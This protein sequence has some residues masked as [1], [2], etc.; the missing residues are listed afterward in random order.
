MDKNDFQREQCV[1]Y[2]TQLLRDILVIENKKP[3]VQDSMAKATHALSKFLES[4]AEAGIGGDVGTD[5]QTLRP[6]VEV[7]SFSIAKVRDAEATVAH[8]GKTSARLCGGR[9]GRQPD[10]E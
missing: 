1:S 2:L 10:S 5:L 4:A 3:V 7:G 8:P 6:L 9:A